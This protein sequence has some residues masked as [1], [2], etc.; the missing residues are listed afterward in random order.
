M[1]EHADEESR[2]LRAQVERLFMDNLLPAIELNDK[3]FTTVIGRSELKQTLLETICEPL[4]QPAAA[5]VREVLAGALRCFS[6]SL[7]AI[8]ADYTCAFT[9]SL[10]LVGASGNGL[11]LCRFGRS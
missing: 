10:L 4:S 9:K 5:R 3:G 1:A 8:V 2:E 6:L 11:Q 7:V